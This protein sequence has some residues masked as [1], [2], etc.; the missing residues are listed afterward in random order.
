MQLNAVRRDLFL[1]ILR[2]VYT[3]KIP[4]M[5]KYIHEPTDNFNFKTVLLKTP[6]SCG[7]GG[8]GGI[9]S[10]FAIDGEPFYI[11][12]PK[13][14]T[15]QGFIKSGKRSYCDLVF[16]VV[17]D[18]DFIRWMENLV[19]HSQKILLEK[20]GDWFQYPISEN[21]IED[22]I[23]SPLKSYKAGKYYLVRCNV[24]S[25]D[26]GSPEIKAYDE[27][28]HEISL[29]SI[30]ESMDVIALLEIRGIK[31]AMKSFQF[32]INIKQIMA[33]KKIN[34]LETCLLSSET[35]TGLVS[36]IT[37]EPTIT[38]EQPI[39]NDIVDTNTTVIDTENDI[40]PK[41]A[42]DVNEQLI[43]E[44][45]PV[46]E[47]IEEMPDNSSQSDDI[48][49]DAANLEEI[50][51]SPLQEAASLNEELEEVNLED[52]ASASGN[53]PSDAE[54]IVLKNP[55]ELYYNMYFDAKKR[56]KEARNNA[57]TAYL[58]AKNIKM[59]YD[60]D[61]LEDSDEDEEDFMDFTDDESGDISDTQS[62][63]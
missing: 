37:Q 42:D 22:A 11:K 50:M 2:I 21:E 14:T 29:A 48:D 41:K 5:E 44:N 60:L 9:F 31:C 24:Q 7:A 49:V 40:E 26:N 62:D 38:T 39:E 35:V 28:A 59:L 34:I 36:N 20:S 45:E 63:D 25:S 32:E 51:P 30:H 16:S 43:H 10:K 46:A 6:F 47:D 3:T 54:P 18:E 1:F 19:L 15:K 8:G 12:T 52:F 58:E 53:E 23:I 13:C 57:I 27:N 4:R 61:N 55:N 56:A 33:V 17:D